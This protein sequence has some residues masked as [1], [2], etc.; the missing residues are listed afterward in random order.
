MAAWYR[1]DLP[2][3]EVP[4]VSVQDVH[5]ERER[6]QLV[7]VRQPGEWEALHIAGALNK[8]LPKLTAMLD[9]LDRERPLAVHCK[10]GY[11]SS[12]ATSLLQRAGFGNVMN[13]TGG[14][15]AWQ[16]CA[17]PLIAPSVM[18]Q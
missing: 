5:R 11:R 17:L 4:Q 1:E 2:V 12:I 8:P 14:I 7:D 18:V 13:V 15:D 10:S 9:G 3:E 16:A 6:V